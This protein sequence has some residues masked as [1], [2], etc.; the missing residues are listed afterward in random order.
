MTAESRFD[1]DEEFSESESISARG[2]EILHV[3]ND[4][5]NTLPGQADEGRD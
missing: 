2:L 5:F 4:V 1:G 3:L